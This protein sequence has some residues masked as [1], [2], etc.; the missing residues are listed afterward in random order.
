MKSFFKYWQASTRFQN[1]STCTYHNL[2]IYEEFHNNSKEELGGA[3]GA[4]IDRTNMYKIL[5]GISLGKGSFGS[6]RR[7]WEGNIET[8]LK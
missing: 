2:Y 3:W 5:V 8:D 4:M 1:R 6:L 7:R